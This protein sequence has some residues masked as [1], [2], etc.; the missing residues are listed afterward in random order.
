MGIRRGLMYLGHGIHHGVGIRIGMGHDGDFS[1][2]SVPGFHGKEAGNDV[3]LFRSVRKIVEAYDDGKA[4]C[5]GTGNKGCGGGA[6]H[7]HIDG[8]TPRGEDSHRCFYAGFIRCMVIREMTA[9]FT[10]ADGGDY[11]ALA[12]RF[13]QGEALLYQG[14]G[15]RGQAVHAPFQY[16]K[17]QRGDGCQLFFQFREGAGHPGDGPH[18]PGTGRKADSRRPSGF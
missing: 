8:I 13:Y 9:F 11:R 17:I 15:Q 14:G 1:Y 3:F 7:F 2:R 6:F 5:M 4:Q 10:G 12:V 16:V 18:A